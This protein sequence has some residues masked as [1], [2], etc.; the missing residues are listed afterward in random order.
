MKNI[1]IEEKLSHIL[2]TIDE[3]SDIV[4]EHENIIKISAAR[5]E[6]L[7]GIIASNQAENNA[8]EYFND[9]KPPHY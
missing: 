8:T 6:R 3:L 1:I 4:A 7:M 5:I 9:A 2:K